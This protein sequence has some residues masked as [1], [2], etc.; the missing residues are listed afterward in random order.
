M[1]R[2]SGINKSKVGFSVDIETWAEFERYCD[3]N[4][5]NKSKLIDRILKDFLKK[6][7]IKFEN[8]Q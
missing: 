4:H 1:A 3:E 5:I 8:V 2:K 6:Q 7:K